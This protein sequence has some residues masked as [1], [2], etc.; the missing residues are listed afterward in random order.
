MSDEDNEEMS[1]DISEEERSAAF[2][3]HR[4]LQMPLEE[5][6]KYNSEAYNFRW[7]FKKSE[8]EQWES[9]FY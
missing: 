3:K 8:E 9:K 6:E 1:D 4:L 5:G 7:A 2:K